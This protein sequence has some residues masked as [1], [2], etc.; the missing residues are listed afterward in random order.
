[1]CGFVL[2]HQSV[3][4]VVVYGNFY[5]T[6]DTRSQQHFMHEI[7][8]IKKACAEALGV[9]FDGIEVFPAFEDKQNFG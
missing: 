9:V 6:A 8:R 4:A 7:C 5:G 2:G 1:M 3:Y